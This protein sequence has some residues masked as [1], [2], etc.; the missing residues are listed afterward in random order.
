MTVCLRAVGSLSP[1]S[2]PPWPLILTREH[3]LTL[4]LHL[5]LYSAFPFDFTAK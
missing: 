5:S 2:L 1:C 3:G 4:C